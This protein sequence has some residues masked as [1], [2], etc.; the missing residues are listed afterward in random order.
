MVMLTSDNKLSK[1]TRRE[2]GKE[3][4]TIAQQQATASSDQM[5]NAVHLQLASLMQQLPDS[6]CTVN[7]KL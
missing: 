3:A 2:R 6:I 1:Q 7:N 5:R 4:T